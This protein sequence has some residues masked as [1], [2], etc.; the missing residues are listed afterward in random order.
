MIANEAK[1]KIRQ[2]RKDGGSVFHGDVPFTLWLADWLIDD[3]VA[4]LISVKE[5][6]IAVQ[7]NIPT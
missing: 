2:R 1:R 4:L 7:S 3:P 6:D 5:P